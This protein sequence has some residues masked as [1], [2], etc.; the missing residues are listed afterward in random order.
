MERRARSG[1]VVAAML[2]AA[3]L[4]ASGCVLVPAPVP[5]FGPPVVVAPPRPVVVI[6]GRPVYRAYHPYRDYHPNPYYHRR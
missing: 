5:V 2:L 6:P 3:S 1:R 4:G